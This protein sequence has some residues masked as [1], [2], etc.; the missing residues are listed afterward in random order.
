MSPKTKLARKKGRV[1]R[2]FPRSSIRD[3]RSAMPDPRS[4]QEQILRFFD[5]HQRDLPWRHDTN[6]YRIWVSEVMLQQTR[7]ETVRAYYQRWLRRFPDLNTLADAPIDDVLKQWE[8][9]G[10][11]S[12]AR[13]LHR[14]AAL[15]REQYHGI[16][17]TDP[18][19]L[20][21]LP[22]IGEYTAGAIASIAY[23]KRT[24]A[25]DGNVKRVL[26]RVLDQPSPSAA[27]LRD[28]AAA[29]VSP[30]RPGDFNQGLM[31]L[32]ATICT[33]RSPKCH[34]CPISRF[35]LA[36]QNGTQLE[37]PARSKAAALPV[38]KFNTVIVRDTEGR[39]LIGRRGEKGLLS[40][41]W[42]FP[43]VEQLDHLALPK[44]KKLLTVRHTFSHFV[45]EYHVKTARLPQKAEAPPLATLRWVLPSHLS[46]YAM[47]AAQRRIAQWIS[48]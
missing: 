43:T 27:L 28:T 37:R 5:Q 31:E 39:V 36:R 3:P 8:G 21:R 11:Y 48:D 16:L 45:G 9:L 24:A 17:P 15:L 12:R 13:N 38:R 40:G 2:A 4:F 26:S 25:I 47:P 20:R 14:A 1:Q 33:P 34:A 44:L 6:P 32:G 46:D 10:Y 7:S 42:E 35:C 41:L 19:A 22:G 23:G 29:L 18:E 30:A